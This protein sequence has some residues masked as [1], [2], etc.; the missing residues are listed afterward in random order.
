MCLNC[1]SLPQHSNTHRGTLCSYT[2]DVALDIEALALT[3]QLRERCGA[4]ITVEVDTTGA[5]GDEGFAVA[6][7]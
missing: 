7:W 2:P 4:D 5:A 1:T 6:E 3:I